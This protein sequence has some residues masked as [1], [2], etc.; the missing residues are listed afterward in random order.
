MRHRDERG[1]HFSTVGRGNVRIWREGFGGGRA[2]FRTR[3]TFLSREE[4]KKQNK[5]KKERKEEKKKGKNE[6]NCNVKRESKV[7][8]IT[9]NVRLLREIK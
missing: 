1:R 7:T 2:S 4:A 5:N 9:T 3:T 6:K 8:D